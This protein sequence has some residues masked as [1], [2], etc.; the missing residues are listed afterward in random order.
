MAPGMV[1][2]PSQPGAPGGGMPHQLA[3]MGV[4]GAGQQINAAALMG[5]VPP[6]AG[7]PNVHALQHLNPNQAQLF[8]QQQFAAN[9]M[10]APTPH[11]S[12]VEPSADVMLCSQSITRKPCN[13]S[14]SSSGYYNSNSRR[15]RPSWLSRPSSSRE[16]ATWPW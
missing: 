15:D 7:G 6:G 13:T 4:S 12:R 11:A 8:Q 1:H 5:G 16:W 3:H 9:C 2:N 14:S 10:A